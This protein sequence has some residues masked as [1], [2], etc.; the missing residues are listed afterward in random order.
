[1]K[2]LPG[3]PAIAALFTCESGEDGKINPIQNVKYNGA[4]LGDRYD[5]LLGIRNVTPAEPIP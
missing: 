5:L 2:G 4:L 3:S 1:M